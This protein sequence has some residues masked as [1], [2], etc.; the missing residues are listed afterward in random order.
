VSR[1]DNRLDFLDQAS[2]LSMRATGREQC[3]QVVWTYEH[4]VDLDGIRRFHT[5]FGYGLIGRRIER[6]PLP[7]GRHR[8]VSS[9]GAPAPLDII[10]EPRP[11]SELSDWLDERSQLHI[12]PERGPGWHVGV[13]PL[14]DGS[15]AVTI[16]MSHCL[17]DGTAGVARL[18]DAMNGQT[19]DMGYPPPR[20]RSWRKAALE[21]ARGTLADLP[22]AG[23]A[24]VGAVKLIA[25]QL[26]PKAKTSGSGTVRRPAPKPAKQAY[27]ETVVP[28]TIY[29]AVDIA[30]WDDRADA[31][32]GNSYALLAGLGTRLSERMGRVNPD[33]GTV[34]LLIALSERT[35]EDTRA[36]AMTLVNVHVDPSGVTT[37]LSAARTAIK[38]AVKAQREAPDEKF[39]LLALTPFTPKRAV[40]S[41]GGLAFGFNDLPVACSNMGEVPDGIGM[42]DGTMAKNVFLLGVD[43]NVTRADMELS[44]GQLV[45]VAGR[46]GGSMSISIL[47]YECGVQNSKARLRDLASNT[48]AEFGL[49][50]TVF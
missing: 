50:G 16:V 19:P 27:L 10:T 43:Q 15:T 5:A 13:L 7:F 31:L 14:S 11:R 41:A 3:M 24:L 34:M 48:L 26:K 35:L 46:I 45:L 47:G 33:T 22:E 30:D 32:H 40:R 25:G 39:G 17:L 8:W 9:L 37:D 49:T 2:F 21:D 12:D 1:I 18:I 44:D 6:S 28:P 20:S 29:V 38:Q 23:R 36:H 4:P 42:V